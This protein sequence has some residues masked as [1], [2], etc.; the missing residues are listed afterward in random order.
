MTTLLMERD[1]WMNTQLSIAR[2]YGG[3]KIEGR[4][5]IIVDKHGIDLWHTS[6]GQG[7]PADLILETIQKAYK[8]LGRDEIIKRIEAGVTE[9]ELVAAGKTARKKKQQEKQQQDTKLFE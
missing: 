2:H 9:E 6:I 1:Y 4:R 3:I 5:Y 7:E 8:K